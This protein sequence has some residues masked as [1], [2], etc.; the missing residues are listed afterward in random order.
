MTFKR[1]YNT[2]KKEYDK[3]AKHKVHLEKKT[4]I[5]LNTEK[6]NLPK[7]VLLSSKSKK[8]FNYIAAEKD[9]IKDLYT[10]SHSGKW[11]YFTFEKANAWSCCMDFKKNSQVLVK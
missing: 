1:L 6:G 3:K 7:S 10:Y 5:G 8:D 2:V 11:A 9:N 4:I